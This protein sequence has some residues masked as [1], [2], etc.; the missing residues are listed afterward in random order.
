MQNLFFGFLIY[1]LS[2]VFKIGQ[3]IP[4]YLQIV[5]LIIIIQ[6]TSK[7]DGK[8][9]TKAKYTSIVLLIA[10]VITLLMDGVLTEIFNVNVASAF[11]IVVINLIVILYLIYVTAKGLSE[12]SKDLLPEISE[13]IMLDFKI[14]SISNVVALIFIFFLPIVAIIG[15]LFVTWGRISF[16]INLKKIVDAKD[17]MEYLARKETKAN[18][19]NK[20]IVQIKENKI[21]VD[22]DKMRRSRRRRK[23]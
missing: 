21:I 11:V 7:L 19:E 23:A 18:I 1:F 15:G 2:D 4:V 16:L 6:S 13:K 22:N 9:F 10:S 12:Y 5:A 3:S 14:I 17:D 8:Y 20:E